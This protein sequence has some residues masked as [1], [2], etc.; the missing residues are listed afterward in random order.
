MQR[1]ADIVKTGS[2]SNRRSV[3]W[4]IKEEL[5]AESETCRNLII[6]IEWAFSIII[7]VFVHMK[8]FVMY[9]TFR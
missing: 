1:R 2:V 3:F 7:C 6:P 8:Q 5:T 9:L 4:C